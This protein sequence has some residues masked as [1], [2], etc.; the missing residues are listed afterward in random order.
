MQSCD[1]GQPLQQNL[2][3]SVTEVHWIEKDTIEQ[4]K[5]QLLPLI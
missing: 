4:L 5:K 3:H 2:Q 1:T